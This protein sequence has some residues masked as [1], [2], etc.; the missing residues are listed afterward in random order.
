MEIR[1]FADGIVRS[2]DLE[3]KLAPPPEPLTDREPGEPLRLAGPGRPPGLE[4]RVAAQAQV[5]GHEGWHDPA[6]RSRIVHALANHELQAA[7]LYAWALLAYADAASEFRKALLG[8]LLEEQRHTRWYVDRLAAW[9]V[10][11]GDFPVSGY[12]WNKAA[13]LTTPLRF[14]CAMALTFENAN[15]DHTVDYAAAAREAGDPE[16]AAIID[17]I[18]ADEAGHVRFG[19]TW[20]LRLKPPDQTPWQAYC[21]NVAWPLRPELARGPRFHPQGRVAAGLD[22]EFIRLLAAT[23]RET[24]T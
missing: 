11:P 15:L 3:H 4:I 7:E 19:W 1:R 17:R 5:P 9:G 10:R 23:E 24:G 18:H 2:T 8:V 13:S 16:T 6:Q 20:L 22:P 21:A 12:F 14:A